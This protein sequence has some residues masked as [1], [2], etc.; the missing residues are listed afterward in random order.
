[1]QTDTPIQNKEIRQTYQPVICYREAFPKETEGD[2]SFVYKTEISTSDL[3][4]LSPFLTPKICAEYGIYPLVS[5]SHVSNS[6]ARITGATENYPIFKL[7]HGG[8][9][10]IYQPL[11][12]KKQYRILCVGNKPKN[13]VYGLNVLTQKFKAFQKEQQYKNFQKFPAAI[14]CN[15]LRDALHL[16]SLGY[17]PLWLGSETSKLTEE[18]YGK[19]M[20]CVEELYIPH[21]IALGSIR[22]NCFSNLKKQTNKNINKK[23][24][25]RLESF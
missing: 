18:Q 8:W 25:L 6:K 11:H 15:G 12:P 4:V 13:Y 23:S 24:R 22:T 3:K 9:S 19:I 10:Q 20:Q 16:A 17:Y 14:L 2:Y 1:M 7:Q 21:N 5:F